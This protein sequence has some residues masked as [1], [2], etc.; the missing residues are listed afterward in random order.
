[1][2]VL[3]FLLFFSLVAVAVSLGVYFFTRDKRYLR[4]TWQLFK[5][6]GILLLIVAT[7]MAVG[8]LLL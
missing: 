6:L 1:M 3:R 8:R 7:V 5:I 2:L 4:F